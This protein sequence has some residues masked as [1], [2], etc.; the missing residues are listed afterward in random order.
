MSEIAW[1]PVKHIETAL[2]KQLPLPLV[3]AAVISSTVTGTSLGIKADDIASSEYEPEYLEVRNFFPQI[4]Q[5]V[6]HL[7][8]LRFETDFEAVHCQWIQLA[9]FQF[10]NSSLQVKQ[11]INI[12][13]QL[14]YNPH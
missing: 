4:S 10:S 12:I 7:L 6:L 8:C 2:Y 1:L 5:H 14:S 13:K 9:W 3:L 11:K